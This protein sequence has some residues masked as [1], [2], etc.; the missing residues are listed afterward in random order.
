MLRVD[1]N[2]SENSDLVGRLNKSISSAD[3]EW[4][5]AAL[6]AR[7]GDVLCREGCFG[8]CIG[9][10]EVSFPEALVLRE[11]VSRLPDARKK[12]VL[13]RAEKLVAFGARF[14]P[15][16][17]AAGILDPDRSEEQDGEFF[18]S[19]GNLAC[20]LLELPGG[21]CAVYESRPVTCRTYGLAWK[22]R[23]EVVHPA[24]PLNLAD[25]APAHTLETA[26]DVAPLLA[27]DQVR[28]E[29]VLAAGFPSGA[30]TTV[31]HALTGTV[32]PEVERGGGETAG[33]LPRHEDEGRT[34]VSGGRGGPLSTGP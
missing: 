4:K 17:P 30:A 24:C 16:D 11:A 22:E 19:V 18:A 14:F 34:A 21:R 23:E 31:A 13:L 26:V 27:G 2:H 1:G 20:P 10:F 28:A 3:S 8:C 29:L 5:R 33:G 7:P 32:F 15:G 12:S 6:A 25:A 9:S